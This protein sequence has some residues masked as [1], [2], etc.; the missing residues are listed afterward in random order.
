MENRPSSD[1]H[2]F[3]AEVNG[4]TF[5][6]RTLNPSMQFVCLRDIGARVLAGSMFA[7][8]EEAEIDA[9]HDAGPFGGDFVAVVQ[10]REVT[11]SE[12]LELGSRL[13]ANP[14]LYR[15]TFNGQL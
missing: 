12:A 10:L 3:V 13:S 4:K 9:A 6:G 1:V 15:D 11:R 2:F 8:R 14:K 7:T 5:I